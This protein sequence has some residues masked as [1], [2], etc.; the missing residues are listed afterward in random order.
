MK[1]LLKLSDRESIMTGNIAIDNIVV[2]MSTSTSEK[3]LSENIFLYL[4]SRLRPL[5]IAATV[6]QRLL[7]GAVEK[8]IHIDVY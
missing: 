7:Q 3:A 1:E 5:F 8:L 2:E 6:F 4:P